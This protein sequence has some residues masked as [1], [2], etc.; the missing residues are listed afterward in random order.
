VRPVAR[1]AEVELGPPADDLAAVVDVVL[2]DR[3]QRQ[4]LGLAVD[5]RQH[6]HVERGL[7]RRVLEEVVQDLVGV[8]V[9]LDLDV[10]PHAVAVRLVA[11]V[12]DAV[13]LLVL[14]EIGDLLE[15]RGLVHLV[16]QLGDDDRHPVAADFLERDLGTHDDAATPVG[17]HLAD[18]VDR[19]PF[20]GQRVALALE[21][22]D[23]RAGRK[24]GA[25]YVLAESVGRDV[26]IVDDRDRRIDDLAEVVGRD[27]RR[28]PDGDPRAAVDQEVRQLRRQDRRLLLGPVVVVDV[29]DGLLVDVGQHLGRHRRQAGLRVPHR[30]RL[31]AVDRPEVALA[32]HERVAHRERLRQSDQRVVAAPAR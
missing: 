15:Q 29:V 4:R 27:V 24:V 21:A 5:E 18:R 2:Q 19:L 28:H 10:H 14:H 20:A 30:G 12:G 17:V 31:V 7:E 26:R 22:E 1:L 25:G 9:A 8:R 11:K 32:V 6:V 23:R 16:R 3:L 13:D